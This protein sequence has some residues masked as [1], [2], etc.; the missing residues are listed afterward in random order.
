MNEKLSFSPKK[1]PQDAGEISFD[2]DHPKD[3]VRFS[4]LIRELQGNEVN[5]SIQRQ[6]ENSG[7][8]WIQIKNR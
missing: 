3:M 4:A 7:L 2:M 5:F 6:G 1:A 8:V